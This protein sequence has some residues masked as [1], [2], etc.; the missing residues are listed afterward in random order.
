MKEHE[1]PTQAG[2]TRKTLESLDRARSGLSEARDWLAS[3]WRPLGT[4][5]PSARGDAWR[6]AQR[7]ISQAK[8]LIDE[9]KATL[10]D[11]EQ[12]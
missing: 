1:L 5:L 10:S 11:A 8:A 12:N 2:I 9:A 7:L 3:D 6:D 4:P